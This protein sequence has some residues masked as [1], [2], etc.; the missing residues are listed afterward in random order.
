MIKTAQQS[1]LDL[2]FDAMPNLKDLQI[3]VVNT[4]PKD[5][6]SRMLYT[7]WTDEA[8]KVAD[9]QYRRPR[10]MTTEEIRSL[11]SAGFV[12]EHGSQL[13]ITNK[14]AS[15]LKSMILQ[16][17]SSSFDFPIKKA[18]SAGTI[19]SK[20]RFYRVASRQEESNRSSLPMN[21]WYKTAKQQ[22]Q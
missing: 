22:W 11:V 17:P 10:T 19:Q 7:L 2:I 3:R 12:V 8:N 21:N 4:G 13:K 14:G 5:P 6:K 20:A 16:D 15:V 9:R 1:L 18:D